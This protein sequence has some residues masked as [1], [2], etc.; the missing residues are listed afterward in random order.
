[1][2]TPEYLYYLI[3]SLT[4]SEKGYFKKHTA[5]HANYIKLFEAIDKQKQYDEAEIKRAF[6]DELFVK[7]L[8]TAKN[9]LYNLI[10]D[11]FRAY[12][13]ERS[14]DIQLKNLL[15]NSE[16]LYEKGLYAQCSKVLAKAKKIAAKYENHLRI[17]EILQ[18]EELVRDTILNITASEKKSDEVLAEE[19]QMLEVYKN[20]TEYRGLDNTLHSL[21]SKEGAARSQDHIKKIEKIMD[22]PLLSNEAQAL[23]IQAKS[24][25]YNIY[26][27]Y[28]LLKGDDMNRYKCEK[29]H[30]GLIEAHPE[31]IQEYL[32]G[33]IAGLIN[34]IIV[35][36][37]IKKYAEALHTLA[38]LRAIPQTYSV[39]ERIELKIFTESYMIELALYLEAKHYEKALAS[40]VEIEK[41]L[42]RFSG[43]ISKEY[44]LVFYNNIANLYFVVGR[45]PD[46]LEW[47]NKILNDTQ[48]SI[49]QDI[50]C[51]ARIFNIIIHYELGNK[52]LLEYLDKSAYRFLDKRGR[53]Y[54][55]ETAFL[56][57]FQKK[58]PKIIGKKELVMAFKDFKKELE[59]IFKDPFE[60]KALEYFDVISWVDGKIV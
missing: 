27:A 20:S 48:V 17:L 1:M 37:D 5:K 25:Y 60:R 36:I 19:K 58:I 56:T 45:Y 8:T 59:Q 41:G 10:L 55:V 49:R 47:V 29:N 23:S 15:I 21:L 43:K 46:S 30:V 18:W 12:H 14:I 57:F 32:S 40:V 51:F 24:H 53:L 50:Y 44:E 28:F 26:G 22:H 33:Y 7:Q 3:K 52:D 31:Q 6:A 2:K 38:K 35:Y 54:K 16:F 4:K 13:T 11:C 34:L 39:S 42:K 9:Y